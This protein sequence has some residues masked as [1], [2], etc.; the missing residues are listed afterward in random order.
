M[1]GEQ[2]VGKYL[3]WRKATN[4][5]A[6]SVICIRLRPLLFTVAS[7]CPGTSSRFARDGRT[8]T[9]WPRARQARRDARVGLMDGERCRS[10]ERSLQR[11]LLVGAVVRVATVARTC[12]RERRWWFGV[13]TTKAPRVGLARSIWKR[14]KRPLNGARRGCLVSVLGYYKGYP[15]RIRSLVEQDFLVSHTGRLGDGLITR[16]RLRWI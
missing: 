13:N 5:S 15:V 7:R 11:E 9:T 2:R 3:G 1:V 10:M 14:K 16:R 4:V 12:W 6:I 8:A